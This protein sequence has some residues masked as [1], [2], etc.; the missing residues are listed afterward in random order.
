MYSPTLAHAMDN[1]TAGNIN[2]H[3]SHIA[4]PFF[5]R[6]L[7]NG[8]WRAANNHDVTIGWVPKNE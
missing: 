8:G 1:Y 2:K 4:E 5:R 7:E 6:N 3:L